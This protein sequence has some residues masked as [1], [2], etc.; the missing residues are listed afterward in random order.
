MPEFGA[1]YAQE[2][3]RRGGSYCSED[4]S[5]GMDAIVSK[6]CAFP[7]EKAAKTVCLNKH[8]F[9]EFSSRFSRSERA[10]ALGARIH[11]H[12]L[13]DMCTLVHI[14]LVDD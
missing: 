7:R 8:T 2:F 10:S 12:R 4:S 13:L 3:L 1:A 9:S 14:L 5:S 6:C 11:W